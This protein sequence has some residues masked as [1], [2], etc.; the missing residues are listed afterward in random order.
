MGVT[1]LMSHLDNYLDYL[2][3][4]KKSMGGVRKAHIVGNPL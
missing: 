4:K 2:S 3:K 1:L